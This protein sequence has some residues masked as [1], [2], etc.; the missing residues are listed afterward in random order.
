MRHVPITIFAI[1]AIVG[2][3]ALLMSVLFVPGPSWMVV[4]GPGTISGDS[5]H[6]TVIAHLDIG[7]LL[8]NE[9][10]ALSSSQLSGLR[11]GTV[12]AKDVSTSYVQSLRFI[13]PG[14]FTGGKIVFSESESNVVSDFLQFTE[15]DGIFKF[16]VE[17]SPGLRSVVEGGN[18][19]DIED[20][21]VFLLG[22]SYTI[23]DAS[24]SGST[25]E[26][27]LFGGYGSIQLK[28]NDFTDNNY[29]SF[30]AQVNGQDVDAR[31]KIRASSSGGKLTIFSISYILVANAAQGGHVEI[32]PLHCLREY[33]R[34]P[35]GLF[36]RNFDI[37]Y[38]GLS[39]AA[40]PS[41]SSISG[42]EVRVRAAGDDEYVMTATNVLGQRYS[43]PLAQ[44]PGMYGNKGRD[45]IFVEAGAP[46]APNIDLG[47]YFLVNSKNDV[48]GAS[49]VLRYNSIDTTSNTVMFEDLAGNSRS[50]TF[51]AGSMEGDLLMS[52]GTYHF[53]IGAGNAIAMDQDNDGTISGD[54]ARFVLA[55]G[56]RVDFGPGFTVTVITPQKLFDEPA[57]DEMTDFDIL[58][59][60]DIDL[61]VPSPQVTVP[62]YTFKM[63][64][65]SGGIKQGLTKYGILF[66]WDEE[67]ES[68][69][70]TL[71]VP[72]SYSG[73]SKGGAGAEVYI[74][75]ERA[76]LM[77]QTDAP[78]PVAKCGDRIITSPE[79]CDPAGS[80]CADPYFGRAGVC[81]ADCMTCTFVPPAQCGNK[82]LEKGEDCEANA[83][84][85]LGFG[86]S[87]CKCY[88]LPQPVCGNNLLDQGEQC[89]KSVDCGAGYV[90][91]SCMCSPAPVVE[92]PAPVKQPN[93]F[94]RFFAWLA[95]LFGG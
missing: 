18:L 8:G 90:C 52:Q 46:A 7:E 44:L 43:I 70:L 15:D 67:S 6:N 3:S 50:A 83:D 59:G 55:G 85:P 35:Q 24:T 23:V 5:G 77:K 51:D 39:G 31:V 2:I 11:S 60:G 26:L 34:Y 95:R 16:Q 79:Y 82:L 38:K 76:K 56:S 32:L 86:C 14:E 92:T 22:D 64:S 84:C 65:E 48:S 37:C 28:D 81:A 21:E 40:V 74:T 78:A 33:L 20:E 9:V 1:V 4:I 89:E 93:I 27:K 10:E 41:A 88:P 63:I 29:Q 73:T 68:D 49:H 25:V 62:G 58:F 61:T 57:G 94:A 80:F 53:K 12:H 71:V 91:S 54:E 19:P 75:L 42:N 66:T 13:E 72:G 17:F 69:D 36:S 87:A 30:G 47:D 45:F